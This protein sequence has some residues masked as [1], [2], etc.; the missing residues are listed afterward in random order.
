MTAGASDRPVSLRLSVTDRCPL[1]CLYCMP[2]EGVRLGSHDE[3]L[4]I[5]QM[6]RFVRVLKSCRPLAKVHITGGE[7]LIR[8][9]ILSLV[10][11]L[12][13]EAVADLAMTTNADGLAAHAPD[14]K[15]A[16]LRR[17]NVSLDS[18]DPRTFAALT[19]GGELSA[20]LTGIDAAVA[21]GLAPVKLNTVVMRGHNDGEVADLARWALDH[22]CAIRFLELMPIGCAA[23]MFRECFVPASEIRSRVAGSFS[24]EPLPYACG[25]SSR[26]FR[27]TDA[28][29]RSGTIGFIAPETQ[30]FC[31]GC[32]R[33][34]LT[35]TGGLIS[36]L[37]RGQGPNV[38]HLLGDESPANHR[39]LQKIIDEALA[40]KRLR[41]AFSTKRA[42]S[43][44]G[45]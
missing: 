43:T 16:G 1:R 31:D 35:S 44:I 45:G 10:E 27:A 17:V 24:F 21:A 6:V 41:V 36:C 14:L 30:P 38:R 12:A 20:V 22:G 8:R 25:A 26:D 13:G 2:A 33:L 18:L 37:A 42:M 3:V 4:R 15:Q 23:G 5:E 32:T 11:M 28:D 39:A 34:R 9:G 7:P 29:G 40:A 19:G